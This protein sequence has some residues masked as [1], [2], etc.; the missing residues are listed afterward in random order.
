MTELNESSVKMCFLQNNF[1]IQCDREPLFLPRERFL[2]IQVPE[3]TV[4]KLVEQDKRL[5]TL[6]LVPQEPVIDTTLN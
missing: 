5:N 1:C 2:K 4:L 6:T 3:A